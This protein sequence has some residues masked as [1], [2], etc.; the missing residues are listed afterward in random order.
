LVSTSLRDAVLVAVMAELRPGCNVAFVDT[1]YHFDSTVEYREQVAR[2]LGVQVVALSSRESRAAHEARLGPTPFRDDPDT[3]CARRKVA[4]LVEVLG[5]YDVWVT[6]VRRADS[7]T[8]AGAAPLLRDEARDVLKVNPLV[9]WRDD[10]VDAF[11]HDRVLPRH[12]LRGEAPGSI[13]CA[14]CTALRPHD[15][16]DPRAGRWPGSAKTECGLHL[17]FE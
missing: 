13:G 11:E 8:R 7:A 1:G 12:P 2:A 3:C 10:D 15:P 6:G 16:L 9:L 5:G 4:P 17:E 14:P